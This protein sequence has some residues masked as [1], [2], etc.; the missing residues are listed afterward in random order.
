MKETIVAISSVG[1]RCDS[2]G[3]S[4]VVV[5]VGAGGIVVV[6]ARGLVRAGVGVVGAPLQWNKKAQYTPATAPAAARKSSA[7]TIRRQQRQSRR[8]D[9][10]RLSSG[11]STSL[12][13]HCSCMLLMMKKMRKGMGGCCIFANRADS[14]WELLARNADVPSL[15]DNGDDLGRSMCNKCDPT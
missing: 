11:I 12:V 2:T 4:V 10:L 6:G 14:R 15:Y 5:V 8:R 3:P 13:A 1:R 9:E 7:A